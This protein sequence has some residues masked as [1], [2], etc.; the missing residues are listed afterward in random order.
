MANFTY[1]SY[2]NMS[3]RTIIRYIFD[4]VANKGVKEGQ[5]LNLV[6]FYD[7]EAGAI[8]EFDIEHILPQSSNTDEDSAVHEIGNLIVIPKQINGILGNDPPSL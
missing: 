2:E 1:L 5:R 4:R 6:D 8:S 3:D 7:T